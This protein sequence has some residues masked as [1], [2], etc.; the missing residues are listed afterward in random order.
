MTAYFFDLDGTL[1][2]SRAGL[3]PAFRRGLEAI[4]VPAVAD[5]QLR[6][7]LGT[8]LPQMFRAMRPDVD[9]R[10]IDAGISAFR[11]A[12]EEVGIISN[13][14]YPG[15]IEMLD[16]IRQ[17]RSKIWVVTSKPEFQ[18]VEVVK[19]LE[20]ERY[21]GGVVGASLAETETKSDLIARALSAAEI[22]SHE[23]VMVGDRSYDIVGALAN[24][25]LPIGALWGYGPEEELRSAGCLH[26]AQT[27]TEFRD[28][29][30]LSDCNPAE[31]DFLAA[32]G[33]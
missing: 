13:E 20:L 22:A 25:V 33:R 30:V 28:A 19:Y 2:D 17:R 12:Y 27:P 29:F 8:P 9:Q 1:T 10:E 18:A 23:A 16:A 15:V 24:H 3:Y 31:M 26:F 32:A 21:V 5:D 11:S 4:G 6:V 7:F 14:L